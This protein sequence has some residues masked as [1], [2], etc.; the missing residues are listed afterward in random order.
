MNE[1]N[2]VINNISLTEGQSMA[3]RVAISNYYLELTTKQDLL[4]DD[5]HGKEIAK[6]YEKRLAETIRLFFKN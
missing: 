4:G 5:K 6:L 2:I 3:V 1:A